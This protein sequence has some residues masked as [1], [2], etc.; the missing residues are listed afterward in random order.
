MR[1]LI[2][3]LSSK[4]LLTVLRRMTPNKYLHPGSTGQGHRIRHKFQAAYRIAMA[5]LANPGQTLIICP[6]VLSSCGVVVGLF[7]RYTSDVQLLLA[8]S[9]AVGSTIRLRV[10]IKVPALEF[11]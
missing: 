7:K 5:A 11:W 6:L 4:K 3:Q 9:R 10:T 2:E 8:P 1:E